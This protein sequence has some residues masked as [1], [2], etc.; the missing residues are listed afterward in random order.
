MLSLKGKD[1]VFS[2]A[3]FFLLYLWN[4][5]PLTGQASCKGNA[6][7]LANGQHIIQI[8]EWNPWNGETAAWGFSS[9]T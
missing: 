2:M 9:I 1:C 4:A 5:L 7:S 3:T 6:N 8:F